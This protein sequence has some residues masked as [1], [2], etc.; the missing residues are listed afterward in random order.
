[1]REM[2]LFVNFQDKKK[3]RALQTLLLPKKI[4]AKYIELQD[5]AQPVGALA[6][7]KELYQEDAVYDGEQLE[8]EMMIFVGLSGSRLDDLLQSMRKKKIAKV[9]YKAI[10]TPTNIHWTI[11]EL[12]QELAKEHEQFNR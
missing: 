11:P 7:M 10:L 8:K 1:M 5:Y 4:G 2:V 6:G 3:L 12:Y 9:D